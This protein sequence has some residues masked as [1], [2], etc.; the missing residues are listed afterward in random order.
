MSF[1]PKDAKKIEAIGS[2]VDFF[3]YEKEGLTYYFFDTSMTAA[4][5]P[6]VNAMSG[7]RLIDSKNKKLQMLNHTIPSGLFPK[8]DEYFKFEITYWEGK[9]LI[10]FSLKEGLSNQAD[11]TQTQCDG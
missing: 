10:T 1:L 9:T 4:P 6:M 2:T 8:I 7:L 11:L 5:E 3:T